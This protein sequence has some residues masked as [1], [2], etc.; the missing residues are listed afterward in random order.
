MY[1]KETKSGMNMRSLGIVIILLSA[2]ISFILAVTVDMSHYELG[3]LINYIWPPF[4][5][6]ITTSLF[7]IVTWITKDS[8][9]RIVAMVVFSLYNLYV[10]FALHIEKDYWPLVVF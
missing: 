3:A 1:T 5:G 10:G 2:F 6:L 8:T 4:I 9:Y 7:L